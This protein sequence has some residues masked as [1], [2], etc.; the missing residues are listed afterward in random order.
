MK[1]KHNISLRPYNT[2]GVEAYAGQLIELE[3]RQE[4]TGYFSSANR[5]PDKLL[6]LGA[7]SNILFTR[8][9]QGVIIRYIN[10]QFKI[11]REDS[12]HVW[13]QCNAGINWHEF[14]LKTIH[15]GFQGLENL[16][17]I[18]GTMGA[19]PV[20]NIGA[21]GVEIK[22][23]LDSVEFLDFRD[24][25]IYTI[26]KSECK[27]KYRDSIFKNELNG[28]GLILNV[29][30]KLNKIPAYRTSYKDIREK[31][32]EM[33]ITDLNAALIS[34]V[35]IAIRKTKLPDPAVTGNAGSFFKNPVVG[36]VEMKILKKDFPEL[37]SFKTGK[38]SYKLS[39]AWLIEQCGWKGYVKGHTGV[40]PHQPLVLI[41]R[42]NAAG[43]EI[44][45]LAQEIKSSVK[46][47]FNIILEPEINVI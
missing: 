19:A 14:V 40:H 4:V 37:P 28:K 24:A 39:A 15:M 36:P 10:K 33:K 47:K 11:I 45:D 13:I 32:D 17:L 44:L 8:D 38:N 27:L 34:S 26:S 7:G 43:Q 31:I 9:F 46:K 25:T 29:T 6:I 3:N 41:N 22:D 35:V 2:F 5:I 23:F 42:G 18:P 1:I 20:Q 21:Y 16:S 30:L 12:R